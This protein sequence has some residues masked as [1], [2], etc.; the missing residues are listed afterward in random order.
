MV[1]DSQGCIPFAYWVSA[2][3]WD[4]AEEDRRR[5]TRELRAE[6]EARDDA[7]RKLEA[8]VRAPRTLIG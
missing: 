6:V 5:E 1:A 4:E 3:R 2:Q 8:R 7:L